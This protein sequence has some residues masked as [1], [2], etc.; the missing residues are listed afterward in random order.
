VSHEHFLGYIISDTLNTGETNQ[1]TTWMDNNIMKQETLIPNKY[2]SVTGNSTRRACVR[3][4]AL[5]DIYCININTLP[6]DILLDLLTLNMRILFCKIPERKII[7]NL[8]QGV[9]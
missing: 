2:N 9:Y 3:S 6:E 7:I 5:A 1:L 4:S 8:V